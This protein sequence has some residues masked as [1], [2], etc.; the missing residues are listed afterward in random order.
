MLPESVVE[1]LRA[2]ARRHLDELM[3][4]LRLPSVA[5]TEPRQCRLCAERLAAHLERL[6]MAAR[7]EGGDDGGPPNVLATALAAEAAAP[8]LLLYGHYDVQPPDPLD[9]WQS[10]PFEPR[11]RDGWLFAR[12]ASDDKGQVMAQLAAVEAWQRAGG[13]LPVHLKVLLEGREEI[14]SPGLEA[15]V[16]ARAA[17]LAADAAVISDTGFLR[18]GLPSITYGLRGLA[19]VEVDFHGPSRDVHSGEHGGAVTNPINALAGLIAAMH[20]ADG[21][22]TLPGFYDDVV[23]LTERERREWA[24]LPIDEAEY[25]R[26]LGV[27]ALGAGERRG[28]T[29][30][31]RRWGRPTLDCN[32]IVG[33]YTAAGSKTIIPAAASA[34]ISMRLVSD[35]DPAKVVEG[36]RQFVAAHT[37]PGIR[38][39][40]RV[41]AESRP[42]LLGR[43][44][45]AM[46]A[47]CAAMEEAFGR[48]PAMIRCG[49]SVP[50]TELIQRLLGLDAVL[51]GFGL[52]EDNVH[53]PN[54]RLRLDQFHRGAVAAAAFLGLLP[55]EL[56][57]GGC[58][59]R[60]PRRWT[61]R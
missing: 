37:P 16:A 1:Y 52:P 30:L 5:N 40:L 57:A 10:P 47:G 55:R 9:Q 32:G 28:Y 58:A 26:S 19:Y 6:G 45:P 7:L 23:E 53:S 61:R 13:G 2:G 11:V 25:A 54:E 31:E 20:D 41:N 59:R 51:L 17:E 49:A 15:F 34:K 60:S 56:S 42:V 21:R 14:G 48:A 46:R 33:G 44:T 12:G 27:E 43:D 4:L 8:T 29:P 18:D 50:V 22:V 36:M 39:E 38:A 3:E 35:Q 24:A